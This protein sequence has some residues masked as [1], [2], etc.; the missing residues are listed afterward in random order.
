M[1][2]EVTFYFDAEEIESNPDLLNE[3]E[4]D[5]RKSLRGLPY[6]CDDLE[7]GV[8]GGV[9]LESIPIETELKAMGNVL[10]LSKK[11][12]DKVNAKKNEK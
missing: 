1:R 11:Y 6:W 8:C 12:F 2:V 7:E 3:V 4:T 9:E 10:Q 5:I